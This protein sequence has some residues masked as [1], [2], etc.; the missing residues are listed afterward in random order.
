M[1]IEGDSY[2]R[3]QGGLYFDNKLSKYDMTKLKTIFL[4]S[5]DNAALVRL[6]VKDHPLK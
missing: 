6:W 4:A 5:E 2:Q 3:I 1:I